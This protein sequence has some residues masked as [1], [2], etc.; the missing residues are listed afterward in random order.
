MIK[1]CESLAGVENTV[2]LLVRK[3]LSK[4]KRTKD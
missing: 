3:T 1:M 2:A 4:I